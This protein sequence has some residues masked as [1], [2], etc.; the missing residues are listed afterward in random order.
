MVNFAHGGAPKPFQDAFPKFAAIVFGTPLSLRPFAGFGPRVGP[1]R[2]DL[3]SILLLSI[4]VVCLACGPGRPSSPDLTPSQ[5]AEII[6]SSPGFN[7]YRQL[8]SVEK[9]LREG[10]SLAECCYNAWFTLRLISSGPQKESLYLQ[11]LS[12]DTPTGLGTYMNIPMVIL[13]TSQ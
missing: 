12:S 7:R 2:Q 6:S 9:T 3:F 1:M 10:D 13:R 8:V 11:W 5:A 4:S